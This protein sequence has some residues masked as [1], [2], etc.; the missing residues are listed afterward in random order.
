MADIGNPSFISSI[1][2]FQYAAQAGFS[3]QKVIGTNYTQKQVIVAI[4]T[5]ESGLD[6]HA[7]NRSDPNG[8]SFG[9]LQINGYW[10]KPQSGPSIS[11]NQ[12]LDPQS[13]FNYAYLAI[14][15]RGNNFAPWSTF[16]SGA[17]KQHI[18]QD[19]P[20]SLAVS[21]L[22]S[23]GWW[24]FNITHGYGSFPDAQGYYF[25]PD[26]NIFGIPTG[27]PIAAILSGTVT[28]THGSD[29][30]YG[31]VV[32]VKLDTPINN[33]ATHY[34]ML[35]MSRVSVAKGTHVNQG[36]ILGYAG[37]NIT[38][39]SAPASLGFALYPGD[40][41]ATDGFFQQYFGSQNKSAPPQL[42]SYEV[43]THAASGM[44]GIQPLVSLSNT[45]LIAGAN[46]FSNFAANITS[47]NIGQGVIKLSTLPFSPDEGVAAILMS[48][49]YVMQIVNPIPDPAIFSNVNDPFSAIG[50]FLTVWIPDFFENIFLDIGAIVL[51]G[52]IIALGIYMVFVVVNQFINITGGINTAVNIAK[53]AAVVGA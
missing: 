24:N 22:P 9:I 44:L 45:P 15:N 8:G 53:T 42:D 5:A 34:V 2:A 4:A 18:Q 21:T 1:Q 47:S 33:L 46:S 28:G 31:A 32:T 38:A 43:A 50:T 19:Q 6:A 12:A 20:T 16:T 40:D 52:S 13:S 41:Y 36:D 29:V 3:D 35:H 17:Y 10:F 25:Q 23:N 51:R 49:D 7:W 39:G 26:N 27:Y 48:I 14:S 11:K 30:S 37:G